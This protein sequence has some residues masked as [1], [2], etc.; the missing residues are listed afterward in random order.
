M[1]ITIELTQEQADAIA[2]Y[3]PDVTVWCQSVVEIS[4]RPVIEQ[5]HKEQREEVADAFMKAPEEV[6][7]QI[8]STLKIREATVEIAEKVSE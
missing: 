2:A 3:N 5:F 6:K 8:K 1:Q 4:T 7:A